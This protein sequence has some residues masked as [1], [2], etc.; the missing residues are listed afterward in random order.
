ML[1]QW[2]GGNKRLAVSSNWNPTYTCSGN[3][4]F[5]TDIV[6]WANLLIMVEHNDY[7]QPI[8]PIPLWSVFEELK[9]HKVLFDQ[10]NAIYMVAKQITWCCWAD[11]GPTSMLKSGQHWHYVSPT[12]I[13]QAAQFRWHRPNVET[14]GQP[15]ANIGLTLAQP[16]GNVF[17]PTI[18]Q[19]FGRLFANLCLLIFPSNVPQFK[20]NFWCLKDVIFESMFWYI[21][22]HP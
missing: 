7:N 2:K 9:R 22:W 15:S 12:S 19:P 21:P 16:L 10:Y 1:S 18:Y 6:E 5:C 4:T 17:L 3:F 8:S 13:C 20:L 14:F 11:I